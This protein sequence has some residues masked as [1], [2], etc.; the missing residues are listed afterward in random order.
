MK[1]RAKCGLCHKFVKIEKVI[2][3]QKGEVAFICKEH[4]DVTEYVEFTK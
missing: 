2:G 4:G 3:G 1:T